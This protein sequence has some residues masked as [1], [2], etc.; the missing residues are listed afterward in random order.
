MLKWLR[1]EF[2][3][4]AGLA[5][6]LAVCAG[7]W[8]RLESSFETERAAVIDAGRQR[9]GQLAEAVR[10]QFALSFANADFVLRTLRSAVEDNPTTFPAEAG[11]MFALMPPG[12]EPR[13]TVFDAGGHQIM[14]SGS[15][16][17]G[18]AGLSGD[19]MF[20][21]LKA[22]PRDEVLLAQPRF[23]PARGRWELPFMR[24]LEE[25]GKFS[26]VIVM[27]VSPLHFSREMERIGLG[28]RDT[29]GATHIP[30]GDY[31][32]RNTGMP[33]LL[34]Q[35]VNPQRPYL[36][37]NA[38]PTGVFI[39][40]ATHEPVERLFA[41]S[42]VEGLPVV[43]FVGLATPDLLSGYEADVA[44]SRFNNGLGTGIVLAVALAACV[45]A[46]HGVRQ[47][48]ALRQQ[49]ALYFNIFE[50]NLSVKYIIDPSDGRIVFANKAA[51][52]FYGYPNDVL[53]GMRIDSINTRPIAELLDKMHIALDGGRQMFIFRHKLSSGE[54][55]TVEVYPSIIELDGRKLLYSI[56]HDITKREALEIKVRASEA[57]YRSLFD[58][59]SAGMIVLD[60]EGNITNWNRAAV[61]ILS[62][63]DAGLRDR[64]KPIFTR[65]GMPV[66]DAE[67]PSRRALQEDLQDELYFT[68]GQDGERVWAAVSSRRLPADETGRPA[69]AVIAVSDIT[70]AVRLEQ[71][72]LISQLVFDTTSEGIVVTDDGERIVQANRAFS[73][74]Y[75]LGA[76]DVIG[77][78]ASALLPSEGS[79]SLRAAMQESLAHKGSW[80]GEVENR[81]KDG[82]SFTER[83]V[84]SALRD[85][86]GRL[87]GAVTLISDVTERKRR[88]EEIWRRANFDMLTGLPN[89]TLLEDRLNQALVHNERLDLPV[90][91]L[92]IDLDRFKPVNDTYGHAA[93]DELLRQV[94]VRI[95]GCVR[96]ADTVARLGGDEFVVLLP[97]VHDEDDAITVA[98]KVLARLNRPFTLP[99]AGA[100]VE[101]S[102]SIGVAVAPGGFAPGAA[103]LARADAAMY[104]GK[105]SGRGRVVSAGPNAPLKDGDGRGTFPA[106]L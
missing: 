3:I 6:V 106:A 41:W 21:A 42:R 38:P 84:C 87:T 14:T 64:A 28:P 51:S 103:L 104:R 34:G 83:L 17:S 16:D 71:R 1:A 35:H 48:R 9:A 32:A 8:V 44:R 33:Q 43:T 102:A 30:D 90:A 58:V 99:E 46:L 10:Q 29:V 74:I 96:S 24:R 73:A 31:I 19:P 47:A 60:G 5:V 39:A 68:T 12:T 79:Q 2:L 40:V 11:R 76:E 13:A 105:A 52:Q 91:V 26:G 61:A 27:S 94:A 25:N 97:M 50:H 15:D 36:P 85:H 88:E 82:T 20:Q 80:E 89:R 101:I 53:V 22:A 59:V 95:Q 70:E 77:L 72:L 45:L 37:L 86:E 66:P 62:T 54:Q 100:T 65:D 67:R 18:A 69:G 7:Y 23:N 75:G 55:R 92:F 98:T 57:L 93:G 78:D 49:R 63:D 56:V 4:A 81:R